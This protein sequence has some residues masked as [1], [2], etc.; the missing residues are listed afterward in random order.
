MITSRVLIATA[1]SCISC[2]CQAAERDP[3]NR[4]H[5]DPLSDL[6]ASTTVIPESIVV[7][8]NHLMFDSVDGTG[9]SYSAEFDPST[10]IVTAISGGNMIQKKISPQEL[11]IIENKAE[12][13]VGL[14]AGSLALVPV[15][16]GV[17]CYVNDQV[18]KHSV[19][20][21]CITQGSTPVMED[22]GICGFGA[23]YRCERLPE[24]PAPK[25]APTPVPGPSG[26]YG[27]I[28]ANDGAG[29]Y[30]PIG[31]SDY[32]SVWTYDSDWF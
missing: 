13:A 11:L 20:R 23:S 5:Q 3:P 19:I 25:P 32:W 29:G 21:A 22:T 14:G 15:F 17:A 2:I 10:S 26:T 27:G 6:P 1:I 31:A 16:M 4:D 24:P 7:H 8:N 9:R 12:Q 30:Y 18:T 28:W